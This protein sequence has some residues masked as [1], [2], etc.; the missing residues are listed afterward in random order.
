VANEAVAIARP[1]RAEPSAIVRRQSSDVLRQFTRNR[2]AVVGL[3]IVAA[4]VLAAIFGPLLLRSDPLEM[5]LSEAYQPPSA[6]HLLGSDE[7]GRDTL[8][9]LVHGAR[10]TLLI[11]LAAVVLSLVFGGAIGL[12]AGFYG[13]KVDNLSMRALDILMA[14]PGFLLAMAV[15]AALGA[16]MVNLIIAVAAVSIPPFARIARG[17]T[18]AVRNQ[19]YILA[20]RALGAPGG[21]LMLAHVLPNIAAP[22]IVQ[23]SLR[24]ATAILTASGLS[25]LGLG[26]PPPTPEWG[27]MLS[28]GRKFIT[29]H[30]ELATYPGLAI[31]FV[32]IGFNLLGDGLR[33]ALDPRLRR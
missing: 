33:D 20:A 31:L 5:N 10:I 14:M 2:G 11:T 19:D 28:T 17:S 27:A 29:S 18:L 12:V 21:R 24:M 9:R 22:L 1:G 8:T 32:T 4:C 15:I 25:F 7:L 23:T 16:G 30:A 6:A 3:A 13:G 26:P